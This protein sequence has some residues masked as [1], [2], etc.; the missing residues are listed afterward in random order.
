[1]K[2]PLLLCFI[3][4]LRPFRAHR[5]HT[6]KKEQTQSRKEKTWNGKLKLNR[7]VPTRPIIFL[8]LYSLA[9]FLTKEEDEE[10]KKVGILLVIYL[11]E[12]NVTT[13][14]ETF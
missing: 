2:S 10:K 12:K 1:M 14:Y 7:T 9:I 6:Y 5:K 3:F 13:N 11:T 4:L 8:F